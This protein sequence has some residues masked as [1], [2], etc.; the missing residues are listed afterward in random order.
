[1]NEIHD[2]FPAIMPSFITIFDWVIL[3]FIVIGVGITVWSIVA[4]RKK[5]T[6]NIQ[7]VQPKTQ[8]FVPEKFSFNKELAVLEQKREQGHWKQFALKSTVLLKKLLEQKYKTPFDFA[9][10]KEMQEILAHKQISQKQKQELARF[11]Q[12]NDPIKFASA[13][14][15][16]DIAKETINILKDFNSK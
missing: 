6:G 8:I 14:G 10:G 1:M 12:L 5:N 11:F 4:S 2:N 15:K 16:D 9:T 7:E 13:Q 3:S